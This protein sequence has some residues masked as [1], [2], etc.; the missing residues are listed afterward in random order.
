VRSPAELAECQLHEALLNVAFDVAIPFWLL[1]PY[2][3]EALAADGIDEAHGPTR[4]EP[5]TGLAR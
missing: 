2:D 3:L 4:S 5:L 1:C